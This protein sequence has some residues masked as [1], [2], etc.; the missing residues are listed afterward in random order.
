VKEKLLAAQQVQAAAVQVVLQTLTDQQPVLTQVA[1]VAVVV[2][3]MATAAQAV[4][5][6]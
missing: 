1:V 3:I 2:T 6:L 4:L 5:V